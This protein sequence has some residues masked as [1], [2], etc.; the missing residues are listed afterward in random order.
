MNLKKSETYARVLFEEDSSLDF[1]ES[2]N[3]YTNIFKEEDS[4][5]S[6]FSSPHLKFEQKKEILDQALKSAPALLKNFFVVLVKNKAFPLLLEIQEMYQK[7]WNDKNKCCSALVFTSQ[8]L[9]EQEKTN[10]KR[11]LEDFFNK[12]IVLQE[13]ED[14]NLI[15]GLK[16]DVEGYVFQANTNHFLKKFEQ[17]GGF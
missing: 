14:K 4:F 1:F 6:F 16:V 2:L 8:A 3:A 10:L 15:A 11:Q 12:K 7:L 9:T 13:K 17:S 5:M